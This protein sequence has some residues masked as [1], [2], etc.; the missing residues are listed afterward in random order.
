MKSH[1]QPIGMAK[2]EFFGDSLVSFGE[3]AGMKTS[4]KKSNKKLNKKTNPLLESMEV[5]TKASQ[6]ETDMR[7]LKKDRDSQ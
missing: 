6:I 1:S 7:S 2:S 3:M 4:K 5:P